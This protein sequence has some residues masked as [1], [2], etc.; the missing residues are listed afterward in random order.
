MGSKAMATGIVSVQR[1]TLGN[2]QFFQ[3]PKHKFVVLISSKKG[4]GVELHELVLE[5]AQVF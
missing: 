5:T 4:D 1:A 2:N 3:F